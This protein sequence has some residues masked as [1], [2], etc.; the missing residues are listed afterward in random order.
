MGHTARCRQK[1]ERGLVT[2]AF[3]SECEVAGGAIEVRDSLD[4]AGHAAYWPAPA[5]GTVRRQNAQRRAPSL[6][7]PPRLPAPEA[8][9]GVAVCRQTV[10]I[11]AHSNDVSSLAT[12]GQPGTQ[13]P[14]RTAIG[15]HPCPRAIPRSQK[16]Q[17]RVPRCQAST[18][19]ASC[20]QNSS[21]YARHGAARAWGDNCS[22]T[23]ATPARRPLRSCCRR[24]RVRHMPANAASCAA[25]PDTQQR[26]Q[27]VSSSCVQ[28]NSVA[29]CCSRQAPK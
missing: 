26:G 4:G 23:R 20:L 13:H 21:H 28:T 7:A 14:L 3:G 6:A 12:S 8:H 29:L 15:R 10:S 22:P 2:G 18:R 25:P 17:C 19:H 11:R 16:V 24:S 9:R 27:G 5:G 1:P